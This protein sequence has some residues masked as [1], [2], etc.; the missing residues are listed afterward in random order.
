MVKITKLVKINNNSSCNNKSFKIIFSKDDDNES[1]EDESLKDDDNESSED[2]S[3]KDDDNESLEDESSKDDDNESLED[4][5]LENKSLED[6]STDK[7][8]SNLSYKSNKL[9]DLNNIYLKKILELNELT[10]KKIS[11][12]EFRLDNLEEKLFINSNNDIIKRLDN[13]EKAILNTSNLTPPNSMIELKKEALNIPEEVVLNALKYKDYRAVLTIFKYYYKNN[14]PIK[15]KGP[16]SFEY[17]S[18]SQWINDLYGNVSINIICLNIQNLFLKYNR[19]DEDT[20]NI[21]DFA[22]TQDFIYKLSDEKFKKSIFKV[23]L[24]E[25][26]LFI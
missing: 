1:S 21:Y 6:E 3:L 7:S 23:I 19:F 22:E 25:I 16:R 17:Y 18:N 15:I 9:D 11:L 14:Y 20:D 13:I 5:S 8:S 10:L 4:E 12:I 2:E 26:Q 24:E